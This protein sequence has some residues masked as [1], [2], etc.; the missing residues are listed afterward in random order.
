MKTNVRKESE[1]INPETRHFM[2]LDVIVP[3]VNLS[4]EYQV[5]RNCS[6][7]SHVIHFHLILFIRKD[8]TSWGHTI[9]RRQL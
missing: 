8:I 5:G 9:N 7:A 4:F 2:E 6:W 1:L 3:S